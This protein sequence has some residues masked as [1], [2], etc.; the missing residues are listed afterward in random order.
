MHSSRRA[1]DQT[2]SASA[3]SWLP[4]ISTHGPS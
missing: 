2:L 1:R 3:A 4:A